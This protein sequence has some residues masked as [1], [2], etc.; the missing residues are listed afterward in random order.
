MHVHGHSAAPSPP[1]QFLRLPDSPRSPALSADDP[2]GLSKH[3]RGSEMR[4]APES[5]LALA[6]P[7]FA[8]MSV[9]LSE[10]SVALE[11]IMSPRTPDQGTSALPSGEYGQGGQSPS[12]RT[13]S[14]IPSS[15][16]PKGGD[17]IYLDQP[18]PMPVSSVP[19]TPNSQT[20]GVPENVTWGHGSPHPLVPST[21]MSIDSFADGASPQKFHGFAQ[22]QARHLST[23][24]KSSTSQSMANR[25]PI[26]PASG[27]SPTTVTGG[28]KASLSSRVGSPR[29]RQHHYPRHGSTKPIVQA[30]KQSPVTVVLQRAASAAGSTTSGSKER[31]QTPTTEETNDVSV[32][33]QLAAH[34]AESLNDLQGLEN[35]S[36]TGTQH[37]SLTV[38]PAP[39]SRRASSH[40]SLQF[41]NR[42]SGS[43]TPSDYSYDSNYVSS[44]S[45]PDDEDDIAFDIVGQVQTASRVWDTTAPVIATT[46]N[47]TR[48]TVVGTA[49]AVVVRSLSV[50]RGAGK[51][52]MQESPHLDA[53]SP[54]SGFEPDASTP[55]SPRHPPSIDSPPSHHT[56]MPESAKS[57]VFSDEA[58]D[59]KGRTYLPYDEVTGYGTNAFWEINRDASS[60]TQASNN[61]PRRRPSTTTAGSMKSVVSYITAKSRASTAASKATGISR[62]STQSTPSLWVWLTKKPL[63]PIPTSS[64]SSPNVLVNTHIDRNEPRLP[65]YQ[66]QTRDVS[67]ILEPGQYRRSKISLVGQGEP[68][69]WNDITNEKW[70]PEPREDDDG[71]ET[72]FYRSI[73]KFDMLGVD[74]LKI[75]KRKSSR[76]RDDP[77]ANEASAYG[78]HGVSNFSD[79]SQR[80]RFLRAPLPMPK[81]KPRKWICFVVM[82]IVT[83]SI[84][85]GASLGLTL[86]HDHRN[87]SP[88]TCGGNKTGT[89]CD[90]GAYMNNW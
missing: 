33:D 74:S 36:P 63:P 12:L 39:Q 35:A 55:T 75:A 65:V 11:D 83:L 52:K 82:G 59:G 76:R 86:G 4:L 9:S 44:D 25:L 41:D 10:R 31:H 47:T 6:S 62:K 66:E 7:G 40:E 32:Q 68:Q 27:A 70:S 24:R 37:D 51:E 20:L 54:T 81:T 69:G 19:V 5:N 29:V 22:A 64:P 26:G 23:L 18:S 49:T 46:G 14:P 53:S 56:D 1:A 67:P 72:V 16:F 48:P 2:H 28:R 42:L 50:D 77:K 71:I 13:R 8:P 57:V 45:V 85:L 60:S 21:P 17:K 87:D 78:P 61:V 90:L 43:R 80:S 89:R 34:G 30:T 88:S 58:H 15:I 3:I 38:P 84:I 79:T 73:G